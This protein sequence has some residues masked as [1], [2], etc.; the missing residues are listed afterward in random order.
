[1]IRKLNLPTAIAL[2]LCLT[3]A[4]SAM[5]FDFAPTSWFAE[6]FEI[7]KEWVMGDDDFERLRAP[8]PSPEEPVKMKT[9]EPG[10]EHGPVV[11]PGSPGC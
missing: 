10:D 4:P 8:Q 1:M 2:V 11:D 5:A 6:F 9:C 7:V 3:V